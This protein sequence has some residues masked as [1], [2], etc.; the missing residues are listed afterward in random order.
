MFRRFLRDCTGASASE[1]ALILAMVGIGIGAA[2][3]VLG[4]NVAFAVGND[5]QE[6]YD[7][8]EAP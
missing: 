6:I 8:N 7:L 5:A 1:Y 4:N 3:M 2:A